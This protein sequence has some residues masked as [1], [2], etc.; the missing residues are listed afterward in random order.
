MDEMRAAAKRASSQADPNAQGNILP[1]PGR[2]MASQWDKERIPTTP[3][4]WRAFYETH[5]TWVYQVV[6]RM[7]GPG[8]E[9]EDA[10]Q[11]VFVV[12]ANKLDT[13]EGRSQLRTW[14]YRICMN[15][16]SEHRRR[17]RRQERIEAAAQSLA[18]WREGPRTAE[19]ELSTRTEAA[20]AHELLAK[21]S[22]RKREVFILRE[23]EQLSGEE[24]AEILNI[25]PATVRT[26]LFHARKEFTRL[27]EKAT[28]ARER[29]AP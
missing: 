17:R 28:A 3:R 29:R 6:R 16:T 12:L 7:A 10:V 8:V 24:V 21:M 2:S 20:L 15:V 18:F 22:D 14:M 26:R 27:L 23:V 25:P 1:F 4:E 5:W 19:H 9:P 13:F 11:D